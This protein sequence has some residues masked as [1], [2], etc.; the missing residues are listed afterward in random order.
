MNI[1]KGKKN[2]E[3]NVSFLSLE[4]HMC[5]SF[6]LELFGLIFASLTAIHP[7]VLSLGDTYFG[8]C[9]LIHAPGLEET[10]WVP[11]L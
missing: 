4:F 8:K 11:P 10:S 1:C 2:N 7:L 5:F 3:E 9:F 6:N